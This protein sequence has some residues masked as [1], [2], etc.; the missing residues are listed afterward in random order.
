MPMREF[1]D[2]GGRMWLVW[3]VHPTLVERRGQD[4][5]PPPGSPE[6]RRAGR[7]RTSLAQGMARGWL[8]FAASDGE[9]RRFAPI[10]QTPVH[11]SE[12]SHEELQAWCCTADV[13]EAP[14]IRVGPASNTPGPLISRPP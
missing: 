5:G 10:P 6:R 12:A 3:D 4:A 8:A 11:W 7:T 13:I 1:T 9:R 2:A 14:S